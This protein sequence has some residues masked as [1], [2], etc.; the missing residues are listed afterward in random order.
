[1]LDAK[2]HAILY[3]ACLTLIGLLLARGRAIHRAI[4]DVGVAAEKANCLSIGPTLSCLWLTSLVSIGGPLLCLFVGWRL[5]QCGGESE[6]TIAVG[7]GLKA[8]GVLWA[9]LEWIR[10]ACCQHGL[11]E[12]HFGWP[13]RAMSVIRR[14]IKLCIVIALPI[15]FVTTTLMSSEG[16]QERGEIQRV[17]FILGMFVIAFFAFRLLRPA[18]VMREHLAANPSGWTAKFGLLFLLCGT[19][20]PLSLAGLAAAGYFYTAQTLFWRL[21]A[22][23]IFVAS[24]VVIRAIL[25]RML[26]LRRRH[27]SMEQARE[28]AAAAKLAGEG[29]CVVEPVAGIVTEDE[30]ADIS[31]AH[32]AVS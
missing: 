9:S 16:I 31:A 7:Q 8:V 13:V 23:C 30:E 18:G 25:Y 12:A 28:R 26:L 5:G 32:S 29:F 1:M 14:H 10:Q 2:R 15:A 17:A 20:L 11:G 4:R 3:L 22:T 19:A 21:V 6:F 24:L 27:L